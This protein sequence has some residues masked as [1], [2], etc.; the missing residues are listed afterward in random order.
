ME[1]ALV[2]IPVLVH[3]CGL[4][5]A[6]MAGASDPLVEASVFWRTCVGQRIPGIT[7]E[8]S[9]AERQKRSASSGSVSTWSPSTS[10]ADQIW[11]FA[12]RRGTRALPGPHSSV[13]NANYLPTI[14][15]PRQGELA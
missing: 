5:F 4:S 2:R 10:D 7:V 6:S 11:S 3:A 8:T 12:T 1:R 15:R 14:R 13:V 9:G